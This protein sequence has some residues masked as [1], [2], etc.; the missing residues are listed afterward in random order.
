ML[1]CSDLFTLN[2][3][4]LFM[5]LLT[6]LNVTRK[7]IQLL[8]FFS[9]KNVEAKLKP[10]RKHI[11]FSIPD[12]IYYIL[13]MVAA[14]CVQAATTLARNWIQHANL[15]KHRRGAKMNHGPK[16]RR[17]E[18]YLVWHERGEAAMADD[19]PLER[20][21]EDPPQPL[22]SVE[23]RLQ[24]RHFELELQALAALL[25]AVHEEVHQLHLAPPPS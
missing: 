9:R 14:W 17:A 3:T 8:L 22:L 10:R 25:V 21:V 19:P 16:Q 12:R 18:V 13:S 5:P 4:A 7:H 23:R 2:V 24:L 1:I 20:A 15:Q 11:R 6:E